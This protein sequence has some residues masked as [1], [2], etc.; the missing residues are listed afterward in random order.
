MGE[1]GGGWGPGGSAHNRPSFQHHHAAG[2]QGWPYEIINAIGQGGM[3]EVGRARDARLQRLV[4]IK[5]LAS[6]ASADPQ[7]HERFE[8]EARAVAA[9]RTPTSSPSMTSGATRG[10]PS[11]WSARGRNAPLT[12]RPLAASPSTAVEYAVQIAAAW[13][14]PTIAASSIAISS[15]RTSS[16]PVTAR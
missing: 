6:H 12:H 5:T 8:R 2:Y 4:A 9:P 14:P 15:R 7:F 13:P 10:S 3:G 1:V 16:S 11:R